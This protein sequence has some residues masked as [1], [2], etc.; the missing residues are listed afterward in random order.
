MSSSFGV[1]TRKPISHHKVDQ[2]QLLQYK[3]EKLENQKELFWKQR[4]HCNW[5]KH[6]DRNTRYFH[7]FASE[8][9]RIN[10]LKKLRNEH[11]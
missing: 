1:E 6:G 8:R 11:V 3:L 10:W 5:L 2:E 7:A 4:S 9:R